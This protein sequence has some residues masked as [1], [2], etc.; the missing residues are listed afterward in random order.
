M[1]ACGTINKLP[2]LQPSSVPNLATQNIS[3]VGLGLRLP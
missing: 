2:Q 3:E 1:A